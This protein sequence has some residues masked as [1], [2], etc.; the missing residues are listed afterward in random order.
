[1][2]ICGAQ[3][4]YFLREL[5]SA[6]LKENQGIYLI[7]YLHIHILVLLTYLLQTYFSGKNS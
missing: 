2:G 3:Y 4:T 1:M 5:F 6:E 7:R